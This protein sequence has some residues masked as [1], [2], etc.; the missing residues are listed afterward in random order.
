MLTEPDKPNG[1]HRFT[2]SMVFRYLQRPSE[3]GEIPE[4]YPCY[5][6][7]LSAFL[8]TSAS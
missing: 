1:P 4:N 7:A 8:I 6:T 2:E 3:I 5:E